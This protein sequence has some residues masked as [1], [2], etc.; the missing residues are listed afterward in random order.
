MLAWRRA[1]GDPEFQRAQRIERDRVYFNPAVALAQADGLRALGQFAYYD[2]AVVH[3][4]DGLRAIRS[5]TLAR[6]RTPAQG[7]GEVPYLDAFL[8]QRDVEMRKE[9]AHSDLSRI[10]T[11]QRRFLRDGNLDL[12]PPLRW[13]TYGDHYAIAR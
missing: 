13:S 11:E 1:A 7:G 2:A 5:R 8:D 4:V 12:L 9:A 10:E 6:A 3:G